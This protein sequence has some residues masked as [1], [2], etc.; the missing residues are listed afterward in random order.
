[1]LSSL[2]LTGIRDE[3]VGLMEVTILS[4]GIKSIPAQKWPPEISG[5]FSY[6]LLLFDLIFNGCNVIKDIP[7]LDINYN[8]GVPAHACIV[9]IQQKFQS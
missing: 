7:V 2:I 1:L 3:S 8:K 6:A 4:P 5:G 9:R